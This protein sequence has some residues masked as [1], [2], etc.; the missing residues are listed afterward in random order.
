MPSLPLMESLYT[1]GF[2]LTSCRAEVIQTYNKGKDDAILTSTTTYVTAMISL[3]VLNWFK[4]PNRS[5]TNF[6]TD[7]LPSQMI[8]FLSTHIGSSLLYRYLEDNVKKIRDE[9]LTNCKVIFTNNLLH[10]LTSSKA[11]TP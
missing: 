8:I 6:F 5:I 3:S 7:F 2:N 4:V 1:P 11:K 9:G 10:S